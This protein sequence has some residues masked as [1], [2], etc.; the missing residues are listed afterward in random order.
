MPNTPSYKHT[1]VLKDEAVAMLNPQPNGIY[2]DAT[3]GGGGHTRTLLE[4]HP[5]IKVVAFDLDREAIE[6]NEPPLKEE[7]GNRLTVL[8]GN[9]S[10]CYKLLKKAKIKAVD[11]VLADF[12]T[13]Q[14]QIFHEEGFSFSRD[15]YLD[16]RMSKAHHYF[17][18]AYV[19]NKFTEREIADILFEYGQES[20]AKR[21]AQMIVKQRTTPIT[22]TL[23]L[24]ELVKKAIPRRYHPDTIHPATKTFQALRIFVNKELEH[25]SLF[26]KNITPFI[27]KEGRLAC[28]SFHSLEDRLVKH[29]FKDHNDLFSIITPKP[30]TPSESEVANNPASRSA[31]L[32]CAQK[33]Y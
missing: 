2:V 12:G 30:V 31:K 24:A 21:I 10:H 6:A 22:T 17:D 14:H 11:G 8:W 28:I 15:T 13:S 1:T 32:R 18:A 16:M 9:F 3:F 20:H 4:A 23:Q 27:K 19:I 33:K 5:T 7:F 25:I 26:L 29:F